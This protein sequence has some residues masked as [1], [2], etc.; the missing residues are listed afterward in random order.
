MSWV[1]RVKARA[2]STDV[3]KEKEHSEKAT[4]KLQA[5]HELAKVLKSAFTLT[6]GPL[7]TSRYLLLRTH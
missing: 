3:V 6:R 4:E 7:C 2:S 5:Y 1:F